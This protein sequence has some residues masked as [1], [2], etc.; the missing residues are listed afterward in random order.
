MPGRKRLTS[1]YL[2]RIR[3]KGAEWKS[4]VPFE[5]GNIKNSKCSAVSMLSLEKRLLKVD[6]EILIILKSCNFKKI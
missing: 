1:K 3:R 6:Y 2:P 4:K 5:K